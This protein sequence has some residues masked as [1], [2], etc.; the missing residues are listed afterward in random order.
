MKNAKVRLEPVT[1]DNWK[2]CAALELAPGQ[3]KYLPSNLYS[4]AESQFYKHSKSVAVYD[5]HGQLIGYALFGRDIFTNTWKI[6]RIMIDR[7]YQ[8]KGYGKSTMKEIIGQISK[9]PDGNEILICY[10]N[11]NQVA[12]KLYASLGFAEQKVDV[13]GKVTALLI[14]QRV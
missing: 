14:P 4:I 5:E 11:D 9:E 2:V 6:F 10:Q 12:R 13:E 7:A 1:V 8:G 3:E